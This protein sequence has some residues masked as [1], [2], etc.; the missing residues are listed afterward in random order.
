[1]AGRVARVLI[2]VDPHK[3]INA[4]VVLDEAGRVL[5]RQTFANTS[6]GY[7]ELLSFA[8]RWRH[9]EWAVEGAGGTGKHL[10]QRLV[11]QGE[12]VIDVPSRKSSLVRAYASNSGRKS[13]DVDAYSVGLAALHNPELERVQVDDQAMKLRLLAHRRDELRRL[14]GQALGRIHRELL[15]LLP[16]GAPRNLSVTKART[17]LASVRP[18]DEVG[19]LR[20]QLVADQ[21]ADL[22]AI[23][24]RLADIKRQITA[25]VQAAPTT[26][27]ELF[28]VGPVITALFV[29]EVRDIARFRNRHHFASY[30]GSAPGLWGSGGEARP[31]VNLR[32]NR[33]LN[34]ALHIIAVSQMRSDTDGRRYY[35]RKIAEGKTKKEALRCLKRRISDTIY[36][37]MVDDAAQASVSPG[38]HLGTTPMTSVAGSTPTAGPSVK[39]QPGLVPD[40]TPVL[41]AVS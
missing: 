11:A 2:A 17:L 14:R 24:K 12:T 26:L 39:P 13:D 7:R 36:R 34:H 21:L 35:L 5:A 37:R 3:R 4:V 16:G 32:G 25:A 8:R 40:R 33:R 6:A 30:N 22:I 27:P 9:R 31:C 38:G 29:G 15:I 19:K 1:M 23:D 10:A 18:R 28:G 20:K 41:A